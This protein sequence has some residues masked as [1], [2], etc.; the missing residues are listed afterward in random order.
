MNHSCFIILVI[1]K[2][3][4]LPTN[5]NPTV[6]R[7]FAESRTIPTLVWRTPAGIKRTLHHHLVTNHTLNRTHSFIVVSGGAKKMLPFSGFVTIPKIAIALLAPCTSITHHFNFVLPGVAHHSAHFEHTFVIS[8]SRFTP[9]YHLSSFFKFKKKYIYIIYHVYVQV[10][11]EIFGNIGV[12][13]NIFQISQIL[14]DTPRC[15]SNAFL[16]A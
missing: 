7:P 3:F 1:E 14:F 10:N 2:L 8:R 15:S 5:H 11:L 6:A 9:C 4:S 13:G 16:Y 12:N